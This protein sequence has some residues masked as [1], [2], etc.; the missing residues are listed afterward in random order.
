[1]ALARIVRF[2]NRCRRA[3][4]AESSVLMLGDIFELRNIYFGIAPYH[5]SRDVVNC[6]NL[7]ANSLPKIRALRIFYFNITWLIFGKHTGREQLAHARRIRT[8]KTKYCVCIAKSKWKPISS[9]YKF[10]TN[11]SVLCWWHIGTSQI[12]A[13]V[14]LKRVACA[15]CSRPV[16]VTSAC[17]RRLDDIQLI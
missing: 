3:T 7:L 5:Y 11:K 17:L 12:I 10:K 8:G 9:T 4:W 6:F 16:C 1:V 2:C 14:V 15:N 13:F